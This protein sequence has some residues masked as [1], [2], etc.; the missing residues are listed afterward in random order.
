MPRVGLN[1]YQDIPPCF[2]PNTLPLYYK[3]SWMEGDTIFSAAQVL[4][5]ARAVL[6]K[7]ITLKTQQ[8]FNQNTVLICC[9]RSNHIS[10]KTLMCQ[11]HFNIETRLRSQ[12]YFNQ[13]VYVSTT[14]QSWNNTEESTL[15][16]G[17]RANNEITLRNQL[18]NNVEDQHWF[19][20]KFVLKMKFH[21]T[22]E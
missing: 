18:W 4:P 19:K 22:I 2:D 15:K 20:V 17:W 1:P 11:P 10:T 12:L 3:S 5:T 6:A 14:F 16:Q 7:I 21:T 13:N 8:N 9:W